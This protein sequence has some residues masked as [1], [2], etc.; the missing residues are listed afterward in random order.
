MAM[1]GHRPDKHSGGKKPQE[2]HGATVLAVLMLGLS[3]S[4]RQGRRAKCEGPET[5][6]K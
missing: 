3:I 1:R 4:G 2:R 5:G 6:K